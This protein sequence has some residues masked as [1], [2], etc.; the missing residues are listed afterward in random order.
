[1]WYKNED[2]MHLCLRIDYFAE[3]VFE[4]FYFKKVK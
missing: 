4:S 1:M 3:S 2:K